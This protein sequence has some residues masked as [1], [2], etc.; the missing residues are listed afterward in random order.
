MAT[1]LLLLPLTS[2]GGFGL[3][4]WWLASQARCQDDDLTEIALDNFDGDYET[5]G[6]L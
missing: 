6:V 5:H 1:L 4:G 3:F 2:V